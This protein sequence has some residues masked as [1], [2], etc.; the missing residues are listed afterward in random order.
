ML[1]DQLYMVSSQTICYSL[2][3]S[4]L[5][6]FVSVRSMCWCYAKTIQNYKLVFAFPDTSPENAAHAIIE[7][8]AA[9]K[10]PSSFMS[11]GPTY[12]WNETVRLV[13]EGLKVPHHFTLPYC[14]WSNGAVECLGKKLLRVF[15]AIL[16][17]LQFYLTE[18]PGLLLIVQSVFNNSSSCHGG[19]IAPTTTFTCMMPTAPISTF[20]Q[21]I[22]HKTVRLSEAVLE[23]AFN[24]EQL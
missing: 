22:S 12:F 16:F 9:F 17:E 13:C 10:V 11:D 23:K 4:N 1:L 3:T 24:N 2:S 14:P 6:I 20:S 18:C 21:T 8:R 5:I 7:S 19:N 15:R